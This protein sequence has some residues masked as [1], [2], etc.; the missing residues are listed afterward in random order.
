MSSATRTPGLAVALLVAGVLAG[1]AVQAEPMDAVPPTTDTPSVTVATVP[2][3]ILDPVAQ[4]L[5]GMG[6]ACVAVL[7]WQE[8]ALA[9]PPEM[10][11]LPSLQP[12]INAHARLEAVR[13]GY[14][15][16]H[17]LEQDIAAILRFYNLP[18]G[19]TDEEALNA[20]RASTRAMYHVELRCR[21]LADG[22]PELAGW[23]PDPAVISM[24]RPG[25]LAAVRA[26][27]AW[28]WLYTD[29]PD[30]RVE[31]ILDRERSVAQAVEARDEDAMWGALVV[32]LMN[33]YTVDLLKDGVE[34][35]SLAFDEV[36]RQCERVIQVPVRLQNR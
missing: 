26:C 30:D 5:E 16:A 29:G 23:V 25:A 20:S 10:L 18:A 35:F 9:R 6:G 4:A 21:Y 19:T 33:L 15:P 22:V 11:R 12:V 27:L 36:S 13:S 34:A 17:Y 28:V 32:A 2:S 7:G 1:C 31:R 3:T 14:K 24:N 8:E